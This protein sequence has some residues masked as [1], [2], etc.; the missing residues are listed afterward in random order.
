MTMDMRSFTITKRKSKETNN[1][2]EANGL[3]LV[4]QNS[5]R[6]KQRLASP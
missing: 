4:K 5:A 6:M 3:N 1:I 2:A